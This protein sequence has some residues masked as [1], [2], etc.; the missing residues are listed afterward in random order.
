MSVRAEPNLLIRAVGGLTN[1]W[2]NLI[3]RG[4]PLASVQADL[5]E[6]DGDRI[7][8]AMNACLRASGGEVSARA[9]A[10]A[11]GRAYLSLNDLGK[12][13]FLEI[14]A[15]FDA[16]RGEVGRAVEALGETADEE[17]FGEAARAL[18]VALQPPWLSL[19][20]QFNELPDGTKFLVDLRAA[21]LD[22]KDPS[23][24]VRR[25]QLD[26]KELLASWFDT[27]FL[28]LRRVTWDASATFLE[29][30]GR[31][32]AVHEVRGWEDL[33]NRLDSDRRC[34]AYVHPAMPKEPL[35]FVEVAL[36]ETMS[37]KIGPLLDSKAP[38]G[39]PDEAS[40][41]IFYSI[42]NCQRGL[43]G[44]S[45]GNALIK[46]VVDA[47]SSEFRRLRVFATLS[48]M[49]GFRRW[50]EAR[51][52]E[53]GAVPDVVTAALS[54]KN[55]QRDAALAATLRGP[56]LRLGAQ[57]LLEA[58]ADDGGASDAVARFHLS[59]GARLERLNWL[60][61]TSAKGIRKAAGMMV[62]YV[63]R[64][65]EIDANHEAYTGDG[66]VAAARAVHDLLKPGR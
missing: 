20:R 19:L 31:Y 23:P 50:L 42:S 2:Q 44:I 57:Y 54:K 37:A 38:L 29:K 40:T 53:D 12:A 47:L 22:L 15:E 66:A 13:R 7:R 1:S 52:G 17:S 16:D 45:F 33:K 48:P 63:Y 28:E 51:A 26:L 18:R 6:R 35:I 46:G 64:I 21:L 49:P 62:N 5:P 56:L 4:D 58:K 43:A 41:A 8:S 39:N 32:E 11:L 61:D 27:G 3:R 24:Q 14:L 59:N 60:A 30:L 36:V 10:A 9:R 34:F 25:L 55:W 65:D